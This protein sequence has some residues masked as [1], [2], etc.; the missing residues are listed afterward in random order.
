[1][2][3][4][5]KYRGFEL[6]ITLNIEDG[7]IYGKIIPNS[8][9]SEVEDDYLISDCFSDVKKTFE[10]E[11]DKFWY[12]ENISKSSYKYKGI[13]LEI[14]EDSRHYIDGFIGTISNAPLGKGIPTFLAET[15]DKVKEKFEQYIDQLEHFTEILNLLKGEK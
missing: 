4:I 11:V 1:M 10:E 8:Y 3:N 6:E 15:V 13:L 2:N 7:L 9:S 12:R 14:D 5:L